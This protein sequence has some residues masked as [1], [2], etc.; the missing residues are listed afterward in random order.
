MTARVSRQLKCYSRAHCGMYICG[1]TRLHKIN[2]KCLGLVLFCLVLM[3]SRIVRGQTPESQ[4]LHNVT[5]C[6]DRYAQWQQVAQCPRPQFSGKEPS[7]RVNPR[8]VI[9]IAVSV[10]QRSRASYAWEK[11]QPMSPLDKANSLLSVLMEKSSHGSFLKRFTA[12][13][14]LSI[15]KSALALTFKRGCLSWRKAQPRKR[16]RPCLWLA[17]SAQEAQLAIPLQNCLLHSGN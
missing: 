11:E 1:I 17:T 10:V 2:F 5:F 4:R 15:L 6:R 9:K 16:C 13:S 14:I 12:K 7:V 8:A 3:A